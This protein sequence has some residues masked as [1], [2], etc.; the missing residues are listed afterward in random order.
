MEV[1]GSF[2]TTVVFIWG[3]EPSVTINRRVGGPLN[4]CG[5]F[6]EMSL[7]PVGNRTVLL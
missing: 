6:G 5:R 1:S 4:R 3:K 2:H 7:V